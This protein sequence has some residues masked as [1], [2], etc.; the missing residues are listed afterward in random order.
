LP[1]RAMTS[2]ETA[3]E[4]F[5][6]INIL[7]ACT[8]SF[9]IHGYTIRRIKL[10]ATS[11]NHYQNF[12]V[13]QSV[14]FIVG[15]ALRLILNE[16]MTLKLEYR[17]GYPFIVLP[18]WLA[19]V[20]SP[21]CVFVETGESSLLTLFNIHRVLLF[22]KPAKIGLFYIVGL[23]IAFFV[24]IPVG[25]SSAFFGDISYYCSSVFYVIVLGIVF[26]C[27]FVLRRHFRD[28]YYS[29][30]IRRAQNKMSKGLLIQIFAQVTALVIVGI[31]PLLSLIAS[32]FRLSDNT[33]EEIIGIYMVVIY[34]VF[35]WFPVLIGFIIKWSI[36]GLLTIKQR[37]RNSRVSMEVTTVKAKE[38]T[39]GT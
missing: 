28:N 27:Y 16:R 5:Q 13:L 8:S 6:S 36:S 37:H 34:A 29:D 21:A 24:T 7:V 33:V 20:L 31:G 3:T 38:K 11:L 23:P 9:L 25:V 32:L 15:S 19:S 10:N 4:I 22:V 26:I 17:T 39:V 2:A 35:I 30:T 12:L 14:V 1:F 18:P